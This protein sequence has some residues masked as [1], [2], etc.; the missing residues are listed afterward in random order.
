[1]FCEEC[2]NS[3]AT[4]HFTEISD[5][6]QNELHLCM[7]CAKNI[8]L[9]PDS[10]THD[11]PLSLTTMLSFLNDE[12]VE[13]ETSATCPECGLTGVELSWHGRPGCPGCY[14]YFKTMLTKLVSGN[15]RMN[16]YS[17]KRPVNFLEIMT[18]IKILARDE[19]Y[20]S[21]NSS[22]ELAEELNK[23]VFE[24]RYEEAAK[25]RDRIRE[26]ETVD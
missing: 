22:A 3:E 2:D 4:F 14:K 25:L 5:N 16:K 10:N 15:K 20:K 19:N 26:V 23:A 6:N 24:E 9:N 1:M 21:I 7:N 17:G 11:H 13:N 12:T 18:D 8:N